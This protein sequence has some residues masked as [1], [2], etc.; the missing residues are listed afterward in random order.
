MQ[1]YF[2]FCFLSVDSPIVVPLCVIIFKESLKMCVL[3]DSSWKL[4]V[5]QNYCDKI[6][7]PCITNQ[8]SL[9]FVCLRGCFVSSI[10]LQ[11]PV[12]AHCVHSL[13]MYLQALIHMN[14]YHCFAAV[15]V[16][17]PPVFKCDIYYFYSYRFYI[18]APDSFLL[19]FYTSS[20]VWLCGR[21]P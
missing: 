4:F 2:L 3:N 21:Q 9:L 11:P 5:F 20:L 8:I 17:T 10:I 12:W 6:Y 16:L 1:K 18:T 13:P 14:M 19:C 7:F 15:K